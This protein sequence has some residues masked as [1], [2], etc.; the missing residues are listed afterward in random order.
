[1]ENPLQ[2]K[3]SEARTVFPCFRSCFS[4]FPLLPPLL[5]PLRCPS[6]HPDAAL[7]PVLFSAFQFLSFF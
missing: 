4:F 5:H 3:E 1:M 7:L 2:N 6:P